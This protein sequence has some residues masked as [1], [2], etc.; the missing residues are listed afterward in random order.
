STAEPSGDLPDQFRSAHR[1]GVDP[2]LVGPRAQQTVRVLGGTH[3]ATDGQWDKDLLGGAAHHVVGG[4]PVAAGGGHVQK[5]QFVG[6]VRAV[7]GGEF[8]R[9]AH[10]T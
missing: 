4:L 2:H 9:V 7:G 3:P 1:G 6:A 5:G 10:L 8:D